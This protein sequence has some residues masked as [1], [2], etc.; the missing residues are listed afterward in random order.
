[1]PTPNTAEPSGQ[2][3]N[4]PLYDAL[5]KSVEQP[6]QH[7]QQEERRPGRSIHDVLAEVGEPDADKPAD[8]GKPAEPA[9]DKPADKPAEP[10]ADKPAEDKPAKVRVTKKKATPEPLPEPD[11]PAEPEPEP[12]KKLAVPKWVNFCSKFAKISYTY[13]KKCMVSRR[14]TAEIFF[15]FFFLFACFTF[16]FSCLSCILF[17][18]GSQVCD[19]PSTVMRSHQY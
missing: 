12:G 10:P 8:K 3:G 7:Q 18:F 13:A 16:S 17:D 11:L 19:S 14:N 4:S 1:M 9:A 5:F 15:C 2:D 6:D